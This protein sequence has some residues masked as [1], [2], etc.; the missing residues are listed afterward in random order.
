MEPA[1][2][3]IICSYNRAHY[4][5]DTLN[6]LLKN[7]SNPNFELLVVDNNSDDETLDIVRKHQ[8]SINKD[9]KPIRYIKE[10]T[11]G[12]SHARNRGIKEANAPNIVFLDD[13]IRASDSLIPAWISF[14]NN[15][16]EAIAG[17]GKIHVQFDAPRPAWM[18]HFLL[19]LL[20]YH[21]LGSSLKTYPKNKYPFGGN[22]GFKKSVFEE[23]G[24]FDTNLGR[25]GASLN[26]GEEKE[27]FRRIRKSHNDIYYV[28]DAFLYH[29]VDA[30]RLT[31]G[32]IRKQALGLGQSM[33]LRLREASTLAKLKIWLSETVKLLGSV[34]LAIGYLFALQPAKATMLF[35][36]RKWIWVGYT[37]NKSL[38]VSED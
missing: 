14:F 4:L 25:K 5:N 16:P 22:M 29:R 21:D 19:P 31:K 18:S 33:W 12:L 15:H 26:A 28:P 20:G 36:F 9:G 30:D 37:T 2:T 7:K 6:S 11:Q 3:F 24:Y 17:G 38:N 35:R 13:D 1:V 34:P 23:V 27:L 10:I 32:Y 8:D